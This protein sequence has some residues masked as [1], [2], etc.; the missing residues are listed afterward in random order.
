MATMVRQLERSRDAGRGLGRALDFM[1]QL[2]GTV[3]ELQ[4]I[5]KRMATSLGVTGP[6]RF[7]IRIVGRYPGIPQGELATIMRIHP[8]TLSGVLARLVQ[9]GTIARRPDPSDRRR[10]LLELTAAGRRIDANREG[11]VEDAVRRTLG[12]LSSR[13]TAAI[14]DVLTVLARDLHRTALTTMAVHRPPT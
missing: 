7:V 11:T 9:R 1:E 6:Q 12:A 2:R 14:R 10:V 13:Q 8:S 4:S 3:H 5:S